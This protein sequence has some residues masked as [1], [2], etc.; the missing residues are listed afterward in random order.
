MGSLKAWLHGLGAAVIGAAAS[1]VTLVVADPTT[2]N[3]K[4]GLGHLGQVC[5][6]QAL[7][8]AAA[9]LKQSPLPPPDSK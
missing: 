5:A 9:Y 4:G 6:V 1:G 2:F 3:F 8:S 7:I